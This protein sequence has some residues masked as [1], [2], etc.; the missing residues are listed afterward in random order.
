[1]YMY[2]RVLDP[3]G[4]IRERFR[5]PSI[6]SI[7]AEI[8]TVTSVRILLGFEFSFPLVQGLGFWGWGTETTQA[9]SLN[10]KSSEAIN[11]KP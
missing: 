1:M 6:Y 5:D 11:P 10:P 9:N 4:S 7:G 8:L 3:N 2:S